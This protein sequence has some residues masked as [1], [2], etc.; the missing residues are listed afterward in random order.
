MSGE[1]LTGAAYGLMGSVPAWLFGKVIPSVE[2][3]VV[4]T[5]NAIKGLPFLVA[6]GWIIGNL[7]NLMFNAGKPDTTPVL[8]LQFQSGMIFGSA[9][10]SFAIRTYERYKNRRFLK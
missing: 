10:G 8:D 9:L 3:D 7:V 4:F 1:F 6:S 5:D 2:T